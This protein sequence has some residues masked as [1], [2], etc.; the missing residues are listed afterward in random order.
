LG[1]KSAIFQC[2]NNEISA[3]CRCLSVNGVS[4]KVTP[5]GKSFHIRAPATEGAATDSR[6]SDSRKKHLTP[7][8]KDGKI[9]VYRIV[10]LYLILTLRLMV[11][12]RNFA[13]T[14]C[15]RNTGMSCWSKGH[16]HVSSVRSLPGITRRHRLCC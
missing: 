3:F 5:D 2:T 6:K 1:R 9:L 4:E 14:S 13:I 7:F 11:S 12:H 10:R 15:F 16:R 8:P